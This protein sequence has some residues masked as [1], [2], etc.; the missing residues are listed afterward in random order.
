M[1][2][3][4]QYNQFLEHCDEHTIG[5]VMYTLYATIVSNKF[6]S[7]DIINSILPI[8]PDHFGDNFKLMLYTSSR[9]DP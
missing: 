1:I 8:I 9:Y 5:F 3:H 7:I 2:F 6:V 4:T